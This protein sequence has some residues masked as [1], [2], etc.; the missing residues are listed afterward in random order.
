MKNRKLFFLLRFFLIAHLFLS[1]NAFGQCPDYEL[2]IINGPLSVCAPS[3]IYTITNFENSPN[4]VYKWTLTSP[5]FPN[6]IQSQSGGQ[7]FIITALFPSLP[8]NQACTI[9]LTL[10]ING[11]CTYTTTFG[12]WLIFSDRL[13]IDFLS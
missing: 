5:L 1:N 6:P 12:T 4:A 9:T 10:T 11:G 13:K 7:V 8:A 3:H 2:P